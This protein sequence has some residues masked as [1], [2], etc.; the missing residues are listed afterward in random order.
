MDLKSVSAKYVELHAKYSKMSDSA[1]QK[2]HAASKEAIAENT[3]ATRALQRLAGYLRDIAAKPSAASKRKLKEAGVRVLVQ[4][5][6]PLSG[7]FPGYKFV[8]DMRGETDVE[9][10]YEDSCVVEKGGKRYYAVNLAT[11]EMTDYFARREVDDTVAYVDGFLRTLEITREMA[12]AKVT[13]PVKEA[14]MCFHSD[15]YTGWVLFEAPK[16]GT[17][18]HMYLD[19]KLPRNQRYAKKNRP[20]L[21]REYKRLAE[22]VAARLDELHGKGIIFSFAGS[23]WLDRSSIA[24]SGDDMFLLNYVSARRAGTLIEEGQKRDQGIV[25]LL[26]AATTDFSREDTTIEL[27]ALAMKKMLVK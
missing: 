26:T 22:G 5:T 3:H 15:G 10:T 20:Q 8:S 24:M 12:S 13:L 16:G 19:E 17:T 1:L 6:K 9:M 4:K 27:I 25:A 14:I 11:Y 18:W 23:R 7:C 2:A 21:E